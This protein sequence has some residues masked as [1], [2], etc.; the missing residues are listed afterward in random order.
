MLEMASCI[1]QPEEDWQ[2]LP[3][4]H[5]VTI[6]KATGYPHQQ[7]LPSRAVRAFVLALAA[8]PALVLS[9]M[10]VAPTPR[11]SLLH[12]AF[13]SRR[14]NLPNVIFQKK[15]ELPGRKPPLSHTEKEHEYSLPHVQS[16]LK[17][18]RDIPQR[19]PKQHWTPEM[20]VTARLVPRVT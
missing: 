18:R 20:G 15:F 12:F 19:G 5:F 16:C 6:I 9:T 7:P 10:G 1:P 4:Q 8:R 13:Q 11:H 2:L 17:C 3:R 14:G